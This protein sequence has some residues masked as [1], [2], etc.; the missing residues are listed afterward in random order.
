MPVGNWRT[1]L[2]GKW[3]ANS[4][5][6]VVLGATGAIRVMGGI[7]MCLLNNCLLNS[8]CVLA[9]LLCAMAKLKGFE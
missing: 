8:V 5:V 1:D 9:C 3:H 6:W 2:N 4:R 7:A